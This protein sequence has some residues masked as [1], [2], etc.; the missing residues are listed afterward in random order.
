MNYFR[1][2]EP[3]QIA[4]GGAWRGRRGRRL[5]PGF[6]HVRRAGGS[7]FWTTLRL[8]FPFRARRDA[9][10]GDDLPGAVSAVGTTGKATR[11]AGRQHLRRRHRCRGATLLFS[12]L[13]QAFLNLRRGRPGKLPAPVDDFDAGSGPFRHEQCWPMHWPVQSSADRRQC[14]KEYAHSLLQQAPTN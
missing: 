8:R 5:D 7:A 10:C 3:G 1:P 12:S 6:Q 13:Q 14:E 11:D 4:A 9:G 2:A